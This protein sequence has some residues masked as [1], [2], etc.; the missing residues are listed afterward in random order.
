MIIVTRKTYFLPSYLLYNSIN[1]TNVMVT[2][3]SKI[4]PKNAF[5]PCLNFCSKCYTVYFIST[6]KKFIISSDHYRIRIK[7]W[8]FVW[9]NRFR[10]KI[11]WKIFRF[12]II[13]N[14]KILPRT[15]LVRMRHFFGLNTTISIAFLY[16]LAYM[17]H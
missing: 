13:I 10:G 6:H 5:A 1:T 17:L 12:S 14:F 2:E 9:I 7:V 11:Y 4:L 16:L 8:H 3:Q 15:L